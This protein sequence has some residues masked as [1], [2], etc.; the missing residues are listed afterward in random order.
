MSRE[1]WS[2]M[3]RGRDRRESHGRQVSLDG[4]SLEG[5]SKCH[6]RA[7]ASDETSPRQ[8]TSSHVS[9]ASACAPE[10][11][12]ASIWS[13]CPY[14]PLRVPPFDACLYFN[15]MNTDD[16]RRLNT[17]QPCAY[18]THC[19]LACVCPYVISILLKKSVLQ[20]LP[21]FDAQIVRKELI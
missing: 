15:V 21:S 3:S 7:R 9:R 2:S 6:S 20:I 18:S 19:N 5:A 11:I 16:K 1:G 14:F 12:G 8:V 4:V 10:R 13:C 17:L